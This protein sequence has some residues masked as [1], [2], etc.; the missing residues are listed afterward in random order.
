MWDGGRPGHGGIERWGWGA[1]RRAGVAFSLDPNHAQENRDTQTDRKHAR[2]GTLP[3][4][5]KSSSWNDLKFVWDNIWRVLDG[6]TWS[7]HY[8]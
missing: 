7:V 6:V 8:I 3:P 1:K 5:D 2:F 4:P